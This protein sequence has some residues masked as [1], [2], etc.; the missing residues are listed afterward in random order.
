MVVTSNGQM[1]AHWMDTIEDVNHDDPSMEL[2]LGVNHNGTVYILSPFGN[3]VYAYNPDGTFGF[4][5]GEQ[6]EQ[7]GQF[8]LS[9]GMLAV[10]EQD[11]LVISDVYRVDLYNADGKY[12][13]RTFTIDYNIAGGS[14]YGM[15]INSSG[16][17]YYIS[18]G[19]KVLK[20]EMNYP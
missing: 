15:T 16:N 8:D 20:F 7:A 5:F 14:M 10:T 4:S 11:Y 17:L 6:G 9:T 12:F 2:V 1:L 18:S 13:N 19:G 3:K